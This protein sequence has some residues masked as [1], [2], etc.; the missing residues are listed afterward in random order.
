MMTILARTSSSER[1]PDDRTKKDNIWWQPFSEIVLQPLLSKQWISFNCKEDTYMARS[2]W[3]IGTENSFPISSGFPLLTTPLIPR[4]QILHWHCS[5]VFISA[6]VNRAEIQ[7][8]LSYFILLYWGQLG[9]SKLTTKIYTI[10]A[11]CSPLPDW[12]A[13]ANTL[14]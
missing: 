9:N 5:S 10:D 4:P 2:R 7:R 11:R 3:W 6:T 8:G 1:T 12:P 14:P 13:I